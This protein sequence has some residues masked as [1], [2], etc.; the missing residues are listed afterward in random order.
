[1]PA[2]DLKPEADAHGDGPRFKVY[3]VMGVP[4]IQDV[5]SGASAIAA[6]Y[7]ES[8]P[9]MVDDMNTMG[10][11]VEVKQRLGS[12]VENLDILAYAGLDQLKQ[13][14]P[15]LRVSAPKLETE[16]SKDSTFDHLSAPNLYITTMTEFVA[17]FAIV[18]L[19]LRSTDAVLGKVEATLPSLPVLGLRRS[20]RALRRAGK[21]KNA[22]SSIASDGTRIPSS[23]S[24][25]GGVLD[26]LGVNYLLGFIG[27]EMVPTQRST[28]KERSTRRRRQ[29][30]ES[31]DEEEPQKFEDLD[32]AR[33]NSESD[34]DYSPSELSGEDDPLEYDSQTEEQEPRFA[35][36]AEAEVVEGDEGEEVDSV[37]IN[38]EDYDSE[39][40]RI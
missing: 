40:E 3:D 2:S 39:G 27:L 11:S 32:F 25:M 17:S 14:L 20:A 31:E 30:S 29:G 15:R 13:R 7:G 34:A 4:I 22:K 1:M 37:E 23:R 24:L 12:A 33:Y 26:I 5:A 36:V 19:L 28:A 10:S 35:E 6:Q 21:R 38:S 16:K 8:L 18:Q 9:S